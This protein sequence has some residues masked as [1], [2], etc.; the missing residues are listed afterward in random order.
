MAVKELDLPDWW[1]GAGFVRNR[2]WDELHG[3]SKPTP[4]GDIDVIYFDT[5]NTSE[6]SENDY[7]KQLEQILPTDLWSVTNQARMYLINNDE[8]YTSSLDAV[9]YWP[10]TATAIAVK[11]DINDRVIFKTTHGSEDL[12]NMIVRPTPVFENRQEIYQARLE[13]KNWSNIW[14]K[15]RFK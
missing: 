4:L 14:P 1:I 7:Q 6:V 5:S 15:L 2:V 12:L 10:E 11:L 3:Y 8:P 9:S 13:K